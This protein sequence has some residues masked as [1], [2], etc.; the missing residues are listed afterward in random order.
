MTPTRRPLLAVALTATIA[1]AA[2]VAA[3]PAQS[4]PRARAVGVPFHGT[5]GPLN[6]IT[7]VGGVEVGD[8]GEA[9]CALGAL[10]SGRCR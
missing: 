9:R 2:A 7:D 1:I 3:V 4:R 5:P 10:L 8:D 6:T